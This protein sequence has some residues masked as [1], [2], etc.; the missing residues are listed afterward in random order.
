MD[1]LL[2]T[3][4]DQT[5]VTPKAVKYAKPREIL[6]DSEIVE[7]KRQALLDQERSEREIEKRRLLTV[8]Q[9][10]AAMKAA[11]LEQQENIKATN[12]VEAQLQ[13]KSFDDWKAKLQ[14]RLTK[15]RAVA[16]EEQSIAK[17]ATD[18]ELSLQQRAY[19][20]WLDKLTA[21]RAKRQSE[22]ETDIQLMQH[23]FDVWKQLNTAKVTAQANIQARRG[24][25]AGVT[26]N[27][28]L[29]QTRA[30]INS[31]LA[32]QQYGA[33]S[34]EAIRARSAEKQRQIESKLQSDL[35]ALN[36][37]F[38]SGGL[39]IPAHYTERTRLLAAYKAEMIALAPAVERVHNLHHNWF[40]N[41]AKFAV[42]YRTIGA[43]MSTVWQGITSVPKVGIELDAV[44]ASLEAT[45]GSTAGMNSALAALDSEANRTG[46]AIGTLREN[47]AQ[48]QASTSL[49]GA[50]L[51]S[52]WS[53]FTNLNTVITGLHLNTDKA[54][55]VFT[56]ITQI[57][58]KSKVQSEELVKQLGN[59]LPGAFASFAKSMGISTEELSKKMKAGTVYA[60]D[61]MEQYLSFMANRFAPAFAAAQDNLNANVGR[62]ES[63]FTHLKET[64]YSSSSGM[65]NSFVKGLTD[66]IK[67]ADGLNKGTEEL[68]ASLK[69][70]LAAA[71]VLVTAELVKAIAT[72][73]SLAEAAVAAKVAMLAINPEALAI[74]AVVV[75]VGFL[76]TKLYDVA[77]AANSAKKTI[78]ELTA[79]RLAD[80]KAIADAAKPK[81]AAEAIK[82]AVGKD[83]TI[84]K[85]KDRIDIYNKEIETSKKATSISFLSDKAYASIA[86]L[87]TKMQ[88]EYKLIAERE[89]VVTKDIT[90]AE[91]KQ[92][93]EALEASLAKDREKI[94]E[95]RL[96]ISQNAKDFEG[97]KLYALK[98]YN[99][100]EVQKNRELLAKAQLDLGKTTDKAEIV[101][102]KQTI[103]VKTEA[104]R[105]AEEDKNSILSELRDKFNKKEE[106]AA[107]KASTAALRQT[108]A[109][110]AID[111]EY[112][113]TIEEQ[114]KTKLANLDSDNTSNIISYERFFAAK[115]AI[116]DKA[117]QDEVKYYEDQKALAQKSGDKQLVTKAT[118]E[119]ERL[120]ARHETDTATVEGD[121]ASKV[122]DLNTELA[123]IHDKY[124]DIIGAER[125]SVEINT[126]KLDLLR[127]QLQAEAA[128]GGESG[129]KAARGLQELGSYEK[130]NAI[131]KQFKVHHEAA[132]RAEKVFNSEIE[133]TRILKDAGVVSE[134]QAAI[135]NTQANKRHIKTIEDEIK[136]NEESLKGTNLSITERETLTDKINSSREALEN[137]KVTSNEVATLFEGKL[138]S[139]FESSFT[140]V[141]TGS[142]TAGDAF[143]SFG[144]SVVSTIA[145]MVAAEA[146][147]T[148][149]KPLFSA[150][151]S[152]I[153]GALG[154]MFAES[155]SINMATSSLENV[156][157][158][159]KGGIYSGAGI[160]SYSGQIVDKPTLFPFAKGTGLMGEAG[161]EA[162]LPLKRNSQGKLGVSLEN[163][164]QAANSNVYYI[165]TTVNTGSNSSADEIGGKVAQQVMR[166]IAKQEI[167]SASRRGNQLNPI[168]KYG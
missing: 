154:G 149:L 86:E 61:T 168:T 148:I 143:K 93:D 155:G 44:K 134:L 124:Q 123:N 167:S 53:M 16:E 66:A 60:Q 30:A 125:D 2:R 45:M 76:V 37:K 9:G 161:A 75:S 103:A 156:N 74:G 26:T 41:L 31:E 32:I 11:A 71:L 59:L 146:R 140:G 7:A 47:F 135:A 69:V 113:K 19:Q 158:N 14:Q 84:Q 166:A 87:R 162:I 120:K 21:R 137:F 96:K 38:T 92:K 126:K 138:S 57:F 108:K 114:A 147:S 159:A 157:Y 28:Q 49:A 79:Q 88:E 99:E 115:Q 62:L 122:N 129:A 67:Y 15:R 111:G 131:Q 24:A 130:V 101:R 116:Y 48:F 106:S 83:E 104:I 109:D 70:G 39:S 142:M 13:Q 95:H 98:G 160:S 139:A 12:L 33:N 127:K 72:F 117:Y 52:T 145:E 141:I 94:K 18:V 107:K 128:M 51:N 100:E 1:G 150:A 105:V 25:Y 82:I 29:A 165:N 43:A 97:A 6:S 64:I 136:A 89:K 144:R 118:Q 85:A 27:E 119:L 112:I 163:G 36:K 23:D 10:I 152:G 68:T 73:K 35:E 55:G 65:M 54:K 42:S 56:A 121:K 40:L 4:A 110:I 90:D 17:A 91:I 77:N 102:I 34:K 78:K 151:F 132:T 50:S 63:A 22:L 20:D 8:R 58:N 80:E 153:T 164:G 81:T 5:P 3:P 46:I 133:R